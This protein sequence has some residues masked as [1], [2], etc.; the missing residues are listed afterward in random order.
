MHGVLLASDKPWTVV[1]WGMDLIEQL[2]EN[3]RARGAKPHQVLEAIDALERVDTVLQLDAEPKSAL[4]AVIVKAPNEA[5][6]TTFAQ[7][8]LDRGAPANDAHVPG[9]NH[10][11]A[12][13]QAIKN[14]YYALAFSLIEQGAQPQDVIHAWLRRPR[15]VGEAKH[16]LAMEQLL[17][18]EYTDEQKREHHV[19]ILASLMACEV[20]TGRSADEDV[21]RG[22]GAMARQVS[23][24]MGWENHQYLFSNLNDACK[25]LRHPEKAAKRVLQA[26]DAW[27]DAI[28]G[29]DIDPK[30][31]GGQYPD[32]PQ[33]VWEQL[34]GLASARA[35]RSLDESTAVAPPRTGG[36]R[37]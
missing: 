30:R 35:A 26:L 27:F 31:W 32:I 29:E 12:I 24:E 37:L 17:W 7:A 8:L 9:Q 14:S 34:P 22:V 33:A 2:K 4:G 28:V 18:R 20:L 21:R 16:Q 11:K 6:A 1:A 3:H 13:N 23:M 15:S 19:A 25:A 10:H 5:Q 36:I